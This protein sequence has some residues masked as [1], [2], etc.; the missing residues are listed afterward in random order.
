[1]TD[2][3]LT[4][5]DIDT[6]E[7]S[8]K[9]SR[10]SPA[11]PRSKTRGK[12]TKY[13]F[14]MELPL[15]PV[16]DNV[17]FPRIIFPLLIG[18][19][20]SVRALEQILES[21]RHILLATQKQLAVEDPEPDDIY[22]TGIVA[23]V[24][25]ILKVPD[26]TIRVMLEGVT[27]FRITK[28]LQSEPFFLV[29]GEPIPH[30]DERDV[31]REALM[32]STMAQFEQIVTAGRFIPPEAV[33]GMMNIEEPGRLADNVAWNLSGL[34]IETKQDLLETLD[35]KQRLEK[36]S[37]ILTKE[38][39][40]L[41]VQKNIRSRVE[42]EMGDNQREFILRE[43][44]KAIQQELGERDDRTGEIEDY[45]QKIEAAKMPEE[46]VERAMKELGRLEK[47][48]YAAPDGVVVRTYLDWLTVLPWST[49]SEDKLD[50]EAA[51]EALDDD[52]YG[53]PKAKERILEF[54]AV[55]KLTGS[56]KGPILCFVGPPGVGKTSIGKSI[57]KALGRK[58]MRVSLG[59]IRDEAEI[60]GHRR[61]YIGSMP[62]RILQGLKQVGTR[63][64]VF[65][66]DEIDKVSA[67]FRGD[68]SSALLE[69]LDPEQNKEFSDHYLEAP[70]D[71]SEVMF[72]TTANLLDP[73]PPALKDRM[74]VIP[75]SGYIEDEKVEI[76]ERFLLPKL[77]REHGL[78][79]GQLTVSRDAVKQVIREH[80]REA[81]V[82]NLERELA[83]VCRKTA[84][85]VAEGNAG[86]FSVDAGDLS[87]FLGKRKYHHGVMEDADQIGAVTGLVYTEFGGDVI[88]IEVT[89]LRGKEGRIT[90]TGQLGDVMKESAQAALSFIRSRADLL[91]LPD[92]FYDHTEIH[93]HVPE[94]AV[95]KDGPSAGITMATAIASALTQ[96]P[97]RKDVAMTGEITLRGRVLPIGGLKEKALAAHRAGIY[98]ILAPVKNE[99]DLDDIPED[100]R[101]EMTFH[102]VADMEQ[103]LSIALLPPA[104]SSDSA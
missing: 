1:M 40:I 54:L 65:M 70:F 63:N 14:P 51:R 93:V 72:I 43:Q 92:D 6:P 58:F 77:I 42:K 84:R 53:I 81:G 15:L 82:R 18:R 68:P 37:V 20:R 71:L 52:H 86:P 35:S 66:L 9:P 96:R 7:I 88:T 102:L 39:E 62:G 95:P 38:F 29:K 36:L 8:E 12:S 34:R 83:S 3:D 98:T 2:I 79:E 101:R 56:L 27:R 74:E 33:L 22:A 16:R 44:L 87:S 100:V 45:R 97:V 25:Q 89:L 78:S 94:G 104:K 23:E 60:R 46:V 49:L 91:R 13:A 76:S 99:N 57:A 73:I 47:M 24:L 26:G 67:D 32:R 11:A 48:P 59:G 64:P 5:L 103:V 10:R 75:F 50:I 61:T 69:A 41:E 4:I 90:L 31:E 30:D 55:R 17:Y 19:E 21:H 80:T 85:K 28:Y